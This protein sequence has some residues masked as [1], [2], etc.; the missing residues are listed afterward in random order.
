MNPETTTLY[1]HSLGAHIVGIAGQN[2][3]KKVNHTIGCDPAWPLFVSVPENE[4][5]SPDDALHVE[6]IHTNAGLWGCPDKLGHYDFYPNGG[7]SQKGCKD[8][9]IS[10]CSHGRSFQYLAEQILNPG[11]DFCSLKCTSYSEFTE[12]TCEKEIA[13]MGGI[14]SYPANPGTYYF[15]TN[16]IEPFSLSSECA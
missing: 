14:S 15:E 11:P 1:G 9:L 4:R 10:A 12:K 13:F 2:V 5:L 16:D 3:T 8:D 6:V 7:S